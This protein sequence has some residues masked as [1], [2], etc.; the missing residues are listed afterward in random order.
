M[1]LDE[2]LISELQKENLELK[3]QIVELNQQLAS[4]NE[5][6]WDCGAYRVE[7]LESENEQLLKEL[8]DKK[9]EFESYKKMQ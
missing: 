1:T 2:Q 6:C 3:S 4:D 5:Q 8:I 9:I 7:Q